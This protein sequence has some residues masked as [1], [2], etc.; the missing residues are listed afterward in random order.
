[1]QT[2]IARSIQDY[3]RKINSRLTVLD[4]LSLT[5]TA[6]VLIT[7]LM[8]YKQKKNIDYHP[9]RYIKGDATEESNNNQSLPFGS[10]NGKT[11]TFNWCSGGKTTKEA[12]K[13]YFKS[14]KEAE[15]L[16]R[17]LSKLCHK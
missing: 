2:N 4:C 8:Y 10:K 14:E 1:M 11:Y 9:L 15:M 17:H 12:N 13:I 7:F 16:G 3:G 6:L 5:I